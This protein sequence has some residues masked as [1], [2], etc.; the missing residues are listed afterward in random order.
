M[1]VLLVEPFGHRGGHFSAHTKYLSEALA[2]A[3]ANVTLV[4]FDGLL[5]ETPKPTTVKRISFVSQSGDW[6]P[7][8]RFVAHHLPRPLNSILITICVFHLA[9]CQDRKEKADVIHVLDAVLPA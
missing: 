1:K 7:V 5:G 8:W 4:T 2:D 9:V 6:G 3:G